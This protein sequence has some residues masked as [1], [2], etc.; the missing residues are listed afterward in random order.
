[1]EEKHVPT[2]SQV[3]PNQDSKLSKKSQVADMFDRIAA[4]YD[5]LNHFLSLGI[6]RLWRRRAIR[7]LGKSHP[8]NL[9]DLATGTGDLAIEASRIPS[10]DQILGLDISEGMLERGKEKI[11][12]L[13]LGHRIRLEKGDGE[14]IPYPQDHFEVISCAYGVRNFENLEKGIREMHRVLQPRGRLVILEFSQPQ[15]FGLKQAYLFY[16]KHILPALGR[17]FSRHDS[18]YSYLPASVAV[19]P[20]GEA[21][22]SILA[23]TGFEEIRHIP[24][25]FGVTTLYL[26]TKPDPE[27]S[28]RS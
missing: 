6:D 7:E 28:E 20:Q 3:V 24:L 18:A 8:R 11:Q 1:M 27:K 16:F 26:A 19:F 25:S 10:L 22:C 13:G 15:W 14:K 4:K 12:K 5:F 21:F 2:L 17:L 9:L 23:K